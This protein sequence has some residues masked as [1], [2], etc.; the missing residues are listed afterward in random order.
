MGV[1]TRA[2]VGFMGVCTRACVG[3]MGVC[4]CMCVGFMGVVSPGAATALVQQFGSAW[5]TSAISANVVCG[6]D[7]DLDT[8]LTYFFLDDPLGYSID[9]SQL[10]RKR[11]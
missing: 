9:G 3:F 6:P 7:P 11:V 8:E 2:C 4:T 5:H 10:E 1:C